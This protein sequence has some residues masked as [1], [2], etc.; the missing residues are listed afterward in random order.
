MPLELLELHRAP[1]IAVADEQGTPRKTPYV[2]ERPPVLTLRYRERPAGDVRVIG[3]QHQI[4]VVVRDGVVV[5]QLLARSVDYSVVA[6]GRGVL[7]VAI[8]AGSAD[9][10]TL[11]P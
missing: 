3:E 6:D 5:G 2:V 10:R 7:T 11:V 9:I 1:R 4:V 8:T